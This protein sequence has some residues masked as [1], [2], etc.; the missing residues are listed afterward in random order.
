MSRPK[1]KRAVEYGHFDVAANEALSEMPMPGVKNLDPEQRKLP[2]R[3][4][5]RKLTLEL[6]RIIKE[7]KEWRD[8]GSPRKLEILDKLDSVEDVRRENIEEMESDAKTRNKHGLFD[9]MFEGRNK[10]SSIVEMI[11]KIAL[12]ID[13]SKSPS[14]NLVVSA[15]KRVI[16]EVRQLNNSSGGDDSSSKN[17]KKLQDEQDKQKK[18]LVNDVLSQQKKS[19]QKFADELNQHLKEGR[20]FEDIAE[21]VTNKVNADKSHH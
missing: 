16:A 9:P 17:V 12:G 4:Q 15:I 18:K 1:F 5:P 14:K 7:W 19:S 10:H 20:S 11:H 8:S 2:R 3:V 13:R 21:I 6:A